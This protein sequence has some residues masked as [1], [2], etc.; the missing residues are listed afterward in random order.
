MQSSK[1]WLFFFP[2]FKTKS[3]GFNHVL[4]STTRNKISTKFLKYYVYYYLLISCFLIS[5]FLMLTSAQ[6][7]GY[8]KMYYSCFKIKIRG[9]E[10][11]NDVSQVIHCPVPDKLKGWVEESLSL[12][13]TIGLAHVFICS[14]VLPAH[15]DILCGS[16]DGK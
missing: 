1:H 10:R 5:Y 15:A 3:S 7:V 12:L 2:F 8:G 16:L 6:Q 14:P 13:L 9:T 11:L 4:V